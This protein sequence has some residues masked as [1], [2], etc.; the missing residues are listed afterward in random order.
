MACRRHPASAALRTDTISESF[1]QIHALRPGAGAEHL[2]CPIAHILV[3]T[4]VL[5]VPV[6]AA[7][8]DPLHGAMAGVA[9]IAELAVFIATILAHLHLLHEARLTAHRKSFGGIVLEQLGLSTIFARHG[10]V[11]ARLVGG[12]QHRGARLLTEL[13]A[14]AG[15]FVRR[16]PFQDAPAIV[17]DRSRGGGRRARSRSGAVAAGAAA[18]GGSADGAAA[19]AA[20]AAAADGAAPAGGAAGGA[21]A[22]AAAP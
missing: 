20:A 18:A 10:L 19:A 3:P 17:Q 9:V 13:H 21:G 15:A 2:Q 12:D 4:F 16:D 1:W 22:G 8:S 11:G 7:L 5:N 14:V 6:M